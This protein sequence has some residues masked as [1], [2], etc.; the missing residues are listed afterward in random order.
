MKITTFNPSII[1]RDGESTIKLF[2]EMGFSAD[3]QQGGKRGRG[4]LSP[5]DEE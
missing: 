4:V 1:T 3:P 5:S 2:E